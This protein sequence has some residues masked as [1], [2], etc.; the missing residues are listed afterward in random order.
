METKKKTD[1]YSFL[2]PI[3]IY[4]YQQYL[5]STNKEKTR[6]CSQQ[7]WKQNSKGVGT[8]FAK[9]L[10]GSHYMLA[11]VMES[12]ALLS[13]DGMLDWLDPVLDIS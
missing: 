4:V 12:V 8:Y 7:L 6:Q 1:F 2:L 11:E 3:V 13:E 10:L 5:N 9:N